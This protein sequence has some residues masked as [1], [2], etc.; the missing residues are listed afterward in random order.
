MPSSGIV[1]SICSFI[2]SFFKESPEWLLSVYI[3][4]KAARGLSSPHSLQH[5]FVG[6]LMMAVLT[7]VR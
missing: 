2:P 6:F 5:L 4:T 1:L 3:P 7:G